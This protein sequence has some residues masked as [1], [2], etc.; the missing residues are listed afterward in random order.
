MLTVF[1]QYII[2]NQWGI[3]KGK[4]WSDQIWIKMIWKHFFAVSKLF[5]KMFIMPF[6]L[7]LPE[8]NFVLKKLKKK[9]SSSKAVTSMI[10][11]VY[12]FMTRSLK[13]PGMETE[14][15]LPNKRD[16]AQFSE[17]IYIPKIDLSQCSLQPWEYW[18]D[19]RQYYWRHAN[20]GDGLGNRN[21]VMR[22][23]LYL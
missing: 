6:A 3:W 22:L 21:F 14:I 10:S 7:K 19:L 5:A 17:A 13:Y 12:K 11:R 4:Q 9:N 15:N 8:Q 1:T 18:S 16:S 23:R 2:L 20:F